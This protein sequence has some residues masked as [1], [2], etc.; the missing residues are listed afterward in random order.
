MRIRRSLEPGNLRHSLVLLAAVFLL[1]GCAG[2]TKARMQMPAPSG[3]NVAEGTRVAAQAMQ[4]M[5]YWPKSQNEASG[6]VTGEKTQK[7]SFGWETMTTTL[8]VSVVKTPEGGLGADAKCSVSQNMAYWSGGREC[9]EQFQE[10][11]RKRLAAW[12]PPVRTQPPPEYR[13]PPPEYRAP[14]P[15]R[16]PVQPAPQPRGPAGKEYNL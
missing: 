14:A 12:Q 2:P 16:A 9:V 4:D 3:I 13:I 1:A 5:G 15:E 10:A 11:F 6:L 8:E 7:I